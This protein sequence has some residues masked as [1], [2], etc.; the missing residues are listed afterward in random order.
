MKAH[1]ITDFNILP[2]RRAEQRR[3]NSD[4][5]PGGKRSPGKRR[6]FTPPYAPKK[7]IIEVPLD[8]QPLSSVV[9]INYHS[10]SKLW[11]G[12]D[13]GG[14]YATDIDMPY[15]KDDILALG[16][17][18]LDMIGT[19]IGPQFYIKRSEWAEKDDEYLD[20]EP[21]STCPIEICRKVKVHK[22]DIQEREVRGFYDYHGT[23]KPYQAMGIEVGKIWHLIILV[24]EI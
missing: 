15:Q 24:E 9:K 10:V 11:S 6:A 12:E 22:V 4:A 2:D 13:A 16:E 20:W 18:Y 21:A 5:W 19:E 3:R 8:D 23:F 7:L 17:D 1:K 14:N